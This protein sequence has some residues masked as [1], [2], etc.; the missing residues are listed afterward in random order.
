MP[1]CICTERNR[2]LKADLPNGSNERPRQWFVFRR[3]YSRSAFNGYRAVW[4][5]FSD[6]SCRV[7][8]AHWRSRASYVAKLD[9]CEFWPRE[10][11]PKVEPISA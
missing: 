2:P 10:R 5:D 9:N 4:S 7:C 6:L 8:G 11:A 3:N 1:A